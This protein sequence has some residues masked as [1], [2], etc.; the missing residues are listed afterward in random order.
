LQSQRDKER[1]LQDFV[2]DSPC[3]IGAERR[4]IFSFEFFTLFNDTVAVQ[5]FSELIELP[6]DHFTDFASSAKVKFMGDA[7]W[8]TY[9]FIHD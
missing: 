8:R 5:D 2:E 6:C 9:L 7:C 4:G 3:S 1:D